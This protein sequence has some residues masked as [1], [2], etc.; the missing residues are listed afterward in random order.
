MSYN[1]KIT[2]ID[3]IQSI[4]RKKIHDLKKRNKLHIDFI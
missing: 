2:V 1:Y 4:S 3:D